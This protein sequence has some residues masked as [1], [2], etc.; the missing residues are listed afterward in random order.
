MRHLKFTVM[1]IGLTAVP[2]FAGMPVPVKMKCAVGGEAFTHITTA[3]YTIFG[4]R[5]DGKPF[6]SWHFP[7]DIPVCPG[8]GLVMFQEEFSAD[9]VKTL[10]VLISSPEY[11]AMRD[12]DT[13]Y[14]KAAWLMR[15]LGRSPIDVAW[16]VVQASW[17]ADGDIPLKQRYQAEYAAAITALPRDDQSIDW[18]LMQARA[19]N[20]YRELE[21][22]DE[23]K[24][25]L[26]GL[27]LASLDVPVPAQSRNAAGEVEN[28]KA[29]EDAENRRG[30]L[31]YVKDVRDLADRR[32]ASS[33]P[34]RMA[35][36]RLAA[37][38]CVNGK[39]RLDADDKAY[40]ES[41]A[42]KAV[43]ARFTLPPR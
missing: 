41:D 9:E 2:A 38:L 33:Q 27:P 25:V 22:F 4:R 23:A 19:G 21:R 12:R 43:I 32:N 28:G 17:Q 3:S 10:K 16:K 31:R 8:N 40:C 36:P 24:A 39:D 30:I 18:M 11:R 42:M 20:A 26:D 7:L 37:E 13:S 29:I 15:S 35:S 5:P 14:Y 6:G 1:A 34:V